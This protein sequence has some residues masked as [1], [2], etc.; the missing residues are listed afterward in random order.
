MTPPRLDGRGCL[1][2]GGTG[3]LGL[4]I[5]RRLVADGAR[6]FVTGK[7]LAEVVASGIPGGALDVDR[8]EAIE[9]FFADALG[10]IGG[11]LDALVHVA[12]RSGRRLGDG[13]LH[14]CSV[15]GWDAVMTTNARG[16]FLTNRAAV[17][18]MVDQAPDPDGHRGSIVNV[19]SMLA[20]HPAPRHFA[21]VAYAAS[22]GA[23]ASMTRSSAAYYASIGVRFNL[24]AP[25][26][27]DTPMA[28][29]A[30]GDPAIRAY[31]ATKQ[32]LCGGPGSAEAVAE[33]VAFLAGPG[34]RLITGTVLQVD[35]GWGVSEGQYRDQP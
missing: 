4:A 3:G 19:G 13:P 30:V 16:A 35:G 27:I 18:I 10:A 14:E 8:P 26:L 31:L 6:V 12:G 5:A 34:S 1:V 17:R 25:G 29:R 20:D 11:R 22:K 9:P 33:A 7:E 15:D 21:T 2:V 32:P 28:A 23:L 24:V